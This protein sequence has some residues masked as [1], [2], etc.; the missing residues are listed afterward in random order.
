VK[1]IVLLEKNLIAILADDH[2]SSSLIKV[3][4]HNEEQDEF[5]EVRCTRDLG[6]IIRIF[7]QSNG[8]QLFC[9][10]TEGVIYDL[11]DRT[12]PPLMAPTPLAK[13][14]SRCP[15]TGFASVDGHVIPPQTTSRKPSC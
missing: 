3:I 10:T 13:F 8:M 6:K 11:G 15:W 1:Q 2:H 4:R 9:E 7:Q 5:E 12:D 14:P